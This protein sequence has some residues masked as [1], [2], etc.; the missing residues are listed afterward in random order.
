MIDKFADLMGDM[1][2][3]KTAFNSAMTRLSGKDNIINQLTRIEEL[4]VKGAK[5][6]P[7]IPE[8]LE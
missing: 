6:I 1:N 2:K 4:G 3:I 7:E 8:N 5:N